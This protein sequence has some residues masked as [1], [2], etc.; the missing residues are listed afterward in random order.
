MFNSSVF[1]RFLPAALALTAVGIVG[2][3][4][5]AAG[6]PPAAPVPIV[7]ELFTSQ[8]CSSCPPADALLSRLGEVDEKG[9]LLIPL[10]YHVDYWNRLGWADPFSSAEWSQ[11]QAA[12]ARVL[13]GGRLYTPQ[14]VINGRHHEVGSKGNQVEKLLAEEGQRQPAA[15]LQVE[16]ERMAGGRL[17]IGVEGRL[18][19]AVE[20]SLTLRVALWESGLSTAVERGENARRNLANDYVVRRLK[21]RPVGLKKAGEGLSETLTLSLDPRWRSE[22][23]GVAVFLQRRD[24]L[25]VVGAA[26]SRVPAS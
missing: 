1:S 13:P 26:V 3:R 9:F 16:A 23:L 10:S 11:R 2:V 15:E 18:R 5:A 25:A 17:K 24:T 7:L 12:Y 14:L 4:S 8:G 22:D 21:S 6:D 20:G 19:S